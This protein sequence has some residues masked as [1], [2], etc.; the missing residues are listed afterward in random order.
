LPR[1]SGGRLPWTYDVDLNLGYRFNL[2]K[3]TSVLVT[4]D[5]F[6]LL[7]LQET[8]SVSTQY[9][10]QSATASKTGGT[11]R[12][13]LVNTTGTATGPFRPLLTTDRDPNFLLPTGYQSPRIFR[14]GIRGTF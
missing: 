1:G 7:D 2:N 3:D 4:L 12:D 14:F 8:T 9:T 5:V 13:V 6:N 10:A 11:L